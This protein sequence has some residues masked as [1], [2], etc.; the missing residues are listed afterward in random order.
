M[1]A[2][3]S[4]ALLAAAASLPLPLFAAD[5]YQ[6]DPFEQATAGFAACPT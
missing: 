6:L 2:L 1:S 3:R 5:S 4:L